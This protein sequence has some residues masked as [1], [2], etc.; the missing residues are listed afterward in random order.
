[1]DICGILVIFL[2]TRVRPFAFRKC[3]LKSEIGSV[4]HVFRLLTIKFYFF[5]LLIFD[6]VMFASKRNEEENFFA[7]KEAKF[8]IFRIISLPNFV[9]DEKKP[10]IFIDFFA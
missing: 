3:S 1:M 6:L 7:S 10:N 2:L 9:S 5:L 8:N 4:S